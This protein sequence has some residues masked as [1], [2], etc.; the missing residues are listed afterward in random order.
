MVLLSLL[1]NCAS[2]CRGP[3]NSSFAGLRLMD[4]LDR[5]GDSLPRSP[6]PESSDLESLGVLA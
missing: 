2:C 5:Y 6:N 4:L 3:N 1:Q